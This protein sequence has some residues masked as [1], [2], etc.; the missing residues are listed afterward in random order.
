[1]KPEN[2]LYSYPYNLSDH[3]HTI[4]FRELRD[5]LKIYLAD[6]GGI[7]FTKQ[8]FD[9]NGISSPDDI[10]EE[11]K[12]AW[13]FNYIDQNNRKRFQRVIL[14]QIFTNKINKIF[15]LNFISQIFYFRY[16]CLISNLKKEPD[17]SNTFYRGSYDDIILLRDKLKRTFKDE[18]QE[19]FK[20]IYFPNLSDK[21]IEVSPVLQLG[22]FQINFA[23]SATPQNYESNKAVIIEILQLLLRCQDD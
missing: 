14:S 1:M 15:I 5:N 13:T 9:T 3:L 16:F 8:F 2:I 7:H 23:D 10:D 19:A 6:I 21:E 18:D 11:K 4:D 22:E 17:I 20:S 12:N